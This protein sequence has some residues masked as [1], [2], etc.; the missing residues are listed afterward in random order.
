MPR[1]KQREQLYLD[2]TAPPRDEDIEQKLENWLDAAD[3]KAAAGEDAKLC[4][5]VLLATLQERKITAYPYRDRA[6]GE[7]RIIRVKAGDP[8]V[9]TAK[10]PK[11]ERVDRERDMA[12]ESSAASRQDAADRALGKLVAA[13]DKITSKGLRVK[14]TPTGSVAA[15]DAAPE[16]DDPF[17]ATRDRMANGAPEEDELTPA[18]LAARE[19]A[20]A[21]A[22]RRAGK[23]TP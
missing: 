6:T 3:A 22:A 20:A 14:T 15:R 21:R 4:H 18:Q 5:Q 7:K 8:K 23:D 19:A 1:L 13:V 9:V 16:D 10:A 2:G 12:G 17:A 11:P